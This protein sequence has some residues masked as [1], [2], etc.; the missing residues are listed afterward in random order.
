MR[1][2]EEASGLE[3][4]VTWRLAGADGT[5]VSERI[6]L[7]DEGIRIRATVAGGGVAG[8]NEAAV[9]FLV[10][11]L[12]DDGGAKAVVT[13]EAGEVECRRGEF[14]FR[15]YCP[16]AALDWE[17]GRSVNRNGVYRVARWEAAGN[18][19]ECRLSLA[20]IVR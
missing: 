11:I 16:G 17:P 14:V 12:D 15:A 18:A 8:V 10:P 6:R 4:E 13:V 20:R 9:R 19:I 5:V 7:E 3:I 1:S 2:L